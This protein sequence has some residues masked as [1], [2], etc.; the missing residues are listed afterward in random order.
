MIYNNIKDVSVTVHVLKFLSS[1]NDNIF[2]MISFKAN[3]RQRLNFDLR[4]EMIFCV[5]NS[6]DMMLKTKL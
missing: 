6:C 1:F 3:K 5:T 4:Y 2:C